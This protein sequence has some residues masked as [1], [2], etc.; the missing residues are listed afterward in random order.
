MKT[1]RWTHKSMCLTLSLTLA[2]SVM[3]PSI[4]GAKP[5]AGTT[6]T[7]ANDLIPNIANNAVISNGN[8]NVTRPGV[9]PRP[10]RPIITA[11]DKDQTQQQGD[12]Q[13]PRVEQSEP[14]QIP[15][16]AGT[17]MLTDL[18]GR[19]SIQVA[20]VPE[21]YSCPLFDNRP[22]ENLNLA[23]DSLTQAMNAAPECRTSGSPAMPGSNNGQAVTETVDQNAKALR[24]AVKSLNGF[25]QNPDTATDNLAGMEQNI[26]AAITAANNI[27]GILSNNALL[28][29][30]CGREMMGTGK[31][32]LAVNDILNSLA[33]FALLAVAVNPGLGMAMKFAITGGTIATSSI[34]AIAKMIDQGTIDMTNPEHRKAVLKNTC[35][36]TKVARKVRFMQLAQS[37][38]IQKITEELNKS[39]RAYEARFSR[40]SAELEDMV[41][42]KSSTD[43]MALDIDAQ[44][45]KDKADLA[46]I[47][48]QM[49]EAAT[50]TDYVCMIAQEMVRQSAR[51]D[52]NVFPATLIQNLD[53]A[54]EFSET[55]MNAQIAGL[56]NLNEASRRRLTSL[57]SKVQGDDQAAIKYCADTARAWVGGLKQALKLTVDMTNTER[58]E[59]DAELGQNSEYKQWAVQSKKLNAEK[60][61]VNRV[62]S[63][64]KE[65]SKDNSVIDRSEMDQRM[66][67]LKSSLFGVRGSWSLGKSPIRAWI[68]HTKGLYE[69]RASSFI[70]NISELK[71]QSWLMTQTGQM[72]TD[73]RKSMSERDRQLLDDVNA[74]NTLSNINAETI[75]VGTRQHEIACQILET[76][77]LDWSAAIDHIGAAE[78]MC[79]MIDPYLDNKV[80][81]SLI[82]TC[83]GQVGLDG[84]Q[85]TASAIQAAKNDLTSPRARMNNKSLRDWALLLGGKM[86]SL[87]C[88][89]PAVNVMQ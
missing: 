25:L 31:V 5:R 64:M 73:Y 38:Q 49:N 20:E 15:G 10:A 57:L 36:Y 28:N 14:A 47:E 56:K 53:Q 80:E 70:N 39:V 23:I 12:Q 9:K 4:G 32:L 44:L 85:Y 19:P 66:S 68:D 74:S 21:E 3:A 22:Y 62:T 72:K 37:G 7:N 1:T 27:G 69:Q 51:A 78:F 82:S 46:Q 71:S 42:Y 88:P 26:T 35:Q 16:V 58:K 86:K 17:P 45:K 52:V 29:S 55:E 48:G 8:R 2:M 84:R 67:L 33:P 77:W 41:T 59:V 79:D 30:R 89:L 18:N 83:R 63:V 43:Q 61:N 65:L 50:N 76:A 75:P 60:Q 40:K 11:G 87:S 54:V 6:T 13:R 34:S 24:D 81:A